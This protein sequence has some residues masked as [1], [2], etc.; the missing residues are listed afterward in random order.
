MDRSRLWLFVGSSGLG[1]LGWLGWGSFDLNW[2][3]SG[4]LGSIGLLGGGDTGSL[5]LLNVLVEQL[6]V[7]FDVG[8]GGLVAVLLVT[9][10][11][12]LSA[13]ALLGDESLDLG[14]LPEGLIFALD[15][16]AVH[17]LANVV[18]ALDE[19]VHFC[20]LGSSLGGESVGVFAIGAALDLLLTLLDNREEDDGEV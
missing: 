5:L 20:D 4:D 2:L 12:E 8:F 15:G 10:D 9:L 16:A 1:S 13:E 6:F 19:S 11:H 17:V 18:L 3:S 14:G 7:F